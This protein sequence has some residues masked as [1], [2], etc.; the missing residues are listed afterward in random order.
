M[1][2]GVTII[3]LPSEEWRRYKELRLEALQDSPTSF[4]TSYVEAAAD[5]DGTW[6][7]ILEKV[8]SSDGQWLRFAE[9]NQKLIG[10]V[11]AYKERSNKTRHR[12]NIIAV[13][14]SPSMRGK[15]IARRLAETLIQDI[16][17]DPEIIAIDLDVTAGN[18]AAERLYTSLGFKEIGYKEKEM[19]ID[20]VYYDTRMMTKF[21]R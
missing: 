7:E 5:P 20:G 12:A 6:E 21:I 11:G 8:Q 13:Y 1:E 10:M 16:G 2:E 14:V 15:G 9:A 3:K 17:A 4:G 19:Y 18:H